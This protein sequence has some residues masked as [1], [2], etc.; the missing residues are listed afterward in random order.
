MLLFFNLFI[1]N[2]IF[3]R[4]LINSLL[5]RDYNIASE[6]LLNFQNDLEKIGL[7]VSSST[8]VSIFFVVLSILISF[9]TFVIFRNKSIENSIKEL[10]NSLIILSFM[11]GGILFSSLYMLRFYNLSRALIIMA[12]I[13][14]PI[15]TLLLLKVQNINLAKFSSNKFSIPAIVVLFS[16][17]AL[18]LISINFINNPIQIESNS[19]QTDSASNDLETEYLDMLLNHEQ[20]LSE[21]LISFEL[22]DNWNYQKISICCKQYSRDRFG[23]PPV[24]KIS[25]YNSDIFFLNSWGE[26]FTIDRDKLFQD[27]VVLMKNLKSNLKE[28]TN[29]NPNEFKQNS[30]YDL[31]VHN[32]KI[33]VSYTNLNWDA[34]CWEMIVFYSDINSL[35]FETFFKTEECITSTE[36]VN[37][38]QSGGEMFP[39]GN[40][41]LLTIGDYGRFDKPQDDESLLGKVLS[42]NIESK[43][44]T[45]ISKGHR[46]SQGIYL[47]NSNVLIFTDHG[48]L[49]G[50]EINFNMLDNKEFKNFGW[51]VSSY[52]YHY[53]EAAKQENIDIAPFHKTHIDYGFIEPAY[54]F[55]YEIYT[56]HGVHS[57]EK[58]YFSDDSFF[59]TSLNGQTLYNFKF[60]FDRNE[61][62]IVNQ[63]RLGERIRDIKYDKISNSYLIVLEGTPALG[64]LR[65]NK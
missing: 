8:S 29:I 58:N 9:I 5:I 46:N 39:D 11:L 27:S 62:K 23:F 17:T 6:N 45:V 34:Q 33:F 1:F 55:P 59:V 2:L 56:S 19:N 3:N 50:D 64:I 60:Y 15:V 28:L 54:Y 65:Y 38:I 14:H 40:Q 57:I 31:L 26:I 41:I 42:I 37:P 13:I 16:L 51:P 22:S 49:G 48:P 7:N 32:D 35:N 30:V 18:L 20:Y 12:F 63:F 10:L 25:L 43:E 24:G 53:S 61:A 44:F 36:Y 21:D 52:G 4:L 47:D